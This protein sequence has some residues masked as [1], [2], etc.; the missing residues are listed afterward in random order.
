MTKLALA[1]RFK[2]SRFFVGEQPGD[3]PITLNQRRVFI[4]PSQRGL[5]FGI[6]ILLLLLIAFV[7]GNN[8][9]YLL[10]F[11]LASVFFITILHTHR[12]LSGLIVRK[13]HCQ[14]VFAGEPA[15]FVLH[16]DNPSSMPRYHLQISLQHSEYLDLAA[17]SSA[18]VTLYANTSQRG[19]QQMGTVTIASTFPFGLFRAWS[20][21]RF[22]LKVLVYPKPAATQLPFPETASATA[23]QGS[24]KLGSD[25][26]YGLRAYQAGDNLKQIDWKT[27]A[28]G[29]GVFSKQYRGE[30]SAEI[31]LDYEQSPGHSSEERLSQLCRW[32]L[33]AEQAGIQYGFSLPGVKLVPNRGLQHCQKCLDA[34]ALF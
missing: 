29:L 32:V 30:T 25:D 27:Y 19:W 26:F 11:L 22:N 1:E 34:L 17:N 20:P 21:L 7:Y 6:L 18:Q 16:I 10:A 28:K 2:L 4:L 24:S 15:G 9:A 12:S 3:K 23:Q 14:N 33:D 13:G 8:L 31:W 5:G